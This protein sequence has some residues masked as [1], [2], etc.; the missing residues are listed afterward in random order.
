ME[1]NGDD[2]PQ[3]NKRKRA[4]KFSSQSTRMAKGPQRGSMETF[5]VEEC[6]YRLK[7]GDERACLAFYRR[8]LADAQ[9]GLCKKL[10][11]WWI[12]AINPNKQT[13][14]PYAGGPE[15]KPNWWPLT[16]PN[17]AVGEPTKGTLENGFVRHKEPDHLSKSGKDPLSYCWHMF[18]FCWHDSERLILLPH[19]L[20]QIVDPCNNTQ[21]NCIDATKLQ[22]IS[23]DSISNES[24]DKDKHESWRRFVHEIFRVAKQQERYKKGEIGEV[25]LYRS[26]YPNLPDNRWHRRYPSPS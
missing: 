8:I 10:A 14:N 20:I 22:Q 4:R 5:P 24:T 13:N 7:V 23:L 16:P 11:K 9:Q 25:N 18:D 19:I 21:F 3:S 15:K 2:S 6:N 17:N 26:R 1:G 12:R